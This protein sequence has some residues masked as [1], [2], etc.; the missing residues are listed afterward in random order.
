MKAGD[1]RREE[2]DA[3]AERVLRVGAGKRTSTC[4]HEARKSRRHLV[5]GPLGPGRVLHLVR[6]VHLFSQRGAGGRPHLR[7]PVQF[8]DASKASGS[9]LASVVACAARR[10]GPDAQVKVHVGRLTE[11][12]R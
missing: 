12:A 2:T 4:L 7:R 9:L 6:E 10:A 11:S 1:P 5:C 8:A 3:L